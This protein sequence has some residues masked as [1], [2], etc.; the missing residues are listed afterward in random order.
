MTEGKHLQSMLLYFHYHAVSTATAPVDGYR[1]Q[2]LQ[3]ENVP[4]ILR[5]SLYRLTVRR[6]EERKARAVY[7][8]QQQPCENGEVVHIEK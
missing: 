3:W 8:I 4:R 2:R 1:L 7:L 6:Y 5:R